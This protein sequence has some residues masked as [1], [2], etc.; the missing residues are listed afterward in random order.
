MSVWPEASILIIGA[1][2]FFAWAYK[3]VWQGPKKARAVVVEKTLQ[4]AAARLPDVLPGSG[5]VF[6]ASTTHVLILEIDGQK[7]RYTANNESWLKAQA[8]D[9][10]KVLIQNETHVVS[11]YVLNRLS[12][13]R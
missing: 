5:G 7:K 8:G 13:D 11:V 9:T 3:N 6:N 4:Q 2:V 10:V 12:T 1:I